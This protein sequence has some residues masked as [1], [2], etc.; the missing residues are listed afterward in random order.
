[1]TRFNTFAAAGLA[2]LLSTAAWADITN[3]FGVSTSAVAWDY[4]AFVNVVSAYRMGQD[5]SLAF[6]NP[7]DTPPYQLNGCDFLSPNP[8]FVCTGVPGGTASASYNLTASNSSASLQS[9]R[10]SQPA[11][12][13]RSVGTTYADL[14]TGMLGANTQANWARGASTRAS[15]TDLLTFNIAGAAPETVTHITVSLAFDRDSTVDIAQGDLRFGTAFATATSGSQV[16][17]SSNHGGWVSGD[18]A[19]AGPTLSVFTGTYALVGATPTLG[20]RTYLSVDTGWARGL[21]YDNTAAF[22]MSLP[23]GVSYSS[24]SGVFLSAV[25]EPGTYALMLA[26]LGAVGL[27]ARRRGLAVSSL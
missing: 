16:V 6:T 13:G 26:G 19:S 9:A 24:A 1:M 4:T 10:L 21:N 15:L 14:A 25:P 11:Y 18:W 23:A 8:D 3:G 5:S 27:M 12:L 2:G 20:L 17:N 7:T 22:Q